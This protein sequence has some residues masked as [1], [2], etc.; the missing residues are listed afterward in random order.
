MARDVF[1]NGATMVSVKGNQNTGINTIT[2]LGLPE[3]PVQVSFD[4]HHEDIIVDAFG[5]NI[6]ID[7]QMFLGA[8]NISMTLIHLDMTVLEAVEQETL[9]GGTSEGLALGQLGTAGQRLGGGNARFATGWHY[10]GLNILSPVGSRPYRFYAAYLTG[11]PITIPL[12]T[13]RSLVQ[14][15]WRAIPYTTDPWGGG[16]GSKGVYLFDRTLD[17]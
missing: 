13:R 4:N 7:V 6:P 16:A 5:P 1:I 17:T 12:G 11:T 9:A 10:V 8:A 15:Q 3:G 2:Q 14:L